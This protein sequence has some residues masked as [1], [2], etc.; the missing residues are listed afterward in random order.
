VSVDVPATA[1]ELFELNVSKSQVR[2]PSFL[3]PELGAI[4]SSVARIAKDVYSEPA[5]GY[6]SPNGHSVREQQAEA[7]RSLVHMVLSAAEEIIREELFH[8]D[9]HRERLIRRLKQM[10]EEFEA[11]LTVSPE[12]PASHLEPVGQLLPGTG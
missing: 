3:R 10:E 8:L 5:H 11:D 9:L 4:A 6:I 12:A 7:V 1:D 2:I